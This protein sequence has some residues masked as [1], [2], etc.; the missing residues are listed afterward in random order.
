MIETTNIIVATA[1]MCAGET[2]G[3]GEYYR[4]YY[5]EL[6]TKHA[7]RAERNS[8]LEDIKAERRRARRERWLKGIKSL[9]SGLISSEAVG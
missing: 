1:G 5:R 9:A 3:A 4:A 6:V 8:R 7:S 2:G